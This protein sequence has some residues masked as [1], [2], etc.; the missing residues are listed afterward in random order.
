MKAIQVHLGNLSLASVADG[1]RYWK[2]SLT[3]KLDFFLNYLKHTA[4]P[5]HFHDMPS[6]CKSGHI[7]CSFP[8][9]CLE[10]NVIDLVMHTD[11]RCM[12]NIT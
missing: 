8:S 4:R 9:A 11:A 6:F 1:N 7:M 12:I 2:G 3:P 5:L 10:Y